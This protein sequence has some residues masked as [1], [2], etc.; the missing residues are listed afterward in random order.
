M[1]DAVRALPDVL[2][3]RREALKARWRSEVA[4]RHP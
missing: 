4:A 3:A 1:L 2:K